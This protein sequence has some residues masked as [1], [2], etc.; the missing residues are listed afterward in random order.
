MNRI[1]MKQHAIES[2]VCL[3]TT[4]EGP[5]HTKSNLTFGCHRPWFWFKLALN[6]LVYYQ[7]HE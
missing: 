7:N 6:D 3:Y 5:H 4:L 2:Y 1:V